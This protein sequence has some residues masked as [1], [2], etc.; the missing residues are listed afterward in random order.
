MKQTESDKSIFKKN[1]AAH[2]FPAAYDYLELLFTPKKAELL[3]NKLKEAPNITKKAKDI[4]RA[5]GL[6][7]LSKENLHVKENLHKFK[8]KQK[9]SPILLVRGTEK[10]IIADGY[11]RLCAAYYL[12]ED[13]NIPCRLV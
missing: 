1:P 6:P 8:K 7:L 12:T 4:F 10:L 2:D 11:H 13:L 9:L 5:S 3:M